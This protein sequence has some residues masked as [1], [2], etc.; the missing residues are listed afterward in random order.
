MQQ[1]DSIE[2]AVNPGFIVLALPRSRT[3][4]L[5]KF[6]TYGDWNCGHDQILNLRSLQDVDS[7]FSQPNVGSVETAGSVWWRTIRDRF[8]GIKLVTI[9]RPVE[10]VV[11][12]LLRL[13]IGFE[14]ESLTKAMVKFDRK[15]DQIEHRV[16][17]VLSVKFD[18]LEQESVC[19]RIFEH[20]LPY[21]HDSD[22]WQGISRINL[23]INFPAMVKY[24]LAHKNQLDKLAKVAK[25]Q[26]IAAFLQRPMKTSDELSIQQESFA[27]VYADGKALFAQHSIQ[28]DESPDSHLTKNLSLMQKLDELGYMQITTARSN[29]KLF[30]YL[31]ALIS[32]ALDRE[33][34]LDAIHLTFFA[35]KEFPGL[36]MKLQRASIAGLKARGVEELFLRAGVRGSGPKMNVLYRRLG[37]EEFGQL[38]SLKLENT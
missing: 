6:L 26:T 24:Y 14:K 12:S 21:R 38:Y 4:W 29:G 25:H 5:S 19:A 34:K 28:V 27:R 13:G 10:Q 32:P 33:N 17:G 16:P 9:R 35:S 30:G 36:G 23:Q 22:W 7:W 2:Q 3:F 31:M 11:D 8:P 18:E 1:N 15:L 37:A 20:C